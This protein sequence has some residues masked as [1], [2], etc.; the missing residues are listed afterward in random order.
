M[1]NINR[2]LDKWKF[3]KAKKFLP[4]NF[5]AILLVSLYKCLQKK[6]SEEQNFTSKNKYE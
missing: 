5:I 6:V 4:H 3:P 2:I 1:Q